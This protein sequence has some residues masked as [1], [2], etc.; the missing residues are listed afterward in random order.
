VQ[1]VAFAAD[2]DEWHKLHRIFVDVA[3]GRSLVLLW[4]RCDIL[5]ELPVS[6]MMSCFHVTGPMARHVYS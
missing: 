4:R 5:Y 1:H 2:I 3:C 6:W